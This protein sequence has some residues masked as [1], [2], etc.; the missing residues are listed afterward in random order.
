MKLEGLQKRF[1]DLHA[2]RD[3][4][5][6]IRQ[7]EFLT[8]LGPS[9][10]GKTTL[11]RIIAGFELADGGRV[12]LGGKDI[13]GL[14]ANVRPIN[15]V[16]QSYALFPHLTVFD[17]VAFGLVSRR[18]PKAE[19]AKKVATALEMLQLGAFASR[20]PHQLSGGQ[21][22]RVALA[23]ALVGEP[24]V[25]LLDEPMSAL[26]AKLRTEVQ[27]ELRRLQKRLGTTFVLVTHDQ[28]EA[29]TVSD[30]ICVLQGGRIQQIGTPEQV[31]AWPCN[32]FVAEFLGAANL[33]PARG[34]GREVD[35]PLGRLTLEENSG[36]TEGTLALRA[37]NVVLCPTRPAVNGVQA[38]VLERIYHGT[39]LEVLLSVA[40]KAEGRGQRANAPLEGVLESGVNTSVQALDVRPS[41]F[42]KGEAFTLKVRTAPFPP[43]EVGEEVWAQLPPH[44]LV[45][46][47]E[48]L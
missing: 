7:G 13:T 2:V 21:K 36:W 43:L 28:D 23:R 47:R 42:N 17:N 3:L 12:V 16:F 32:R 34:N 26:D 11:L 41:T 19:I 20:H 45:P 33:I 15:T 1:G 5:L 27:L 44:A 4:S 46:L 29:M 39:H 48:D 6:D 25:L 14:P 40:Q 10:C 18:T 38:T 37:E 24:E 8:L 22:Q 31:Y 9:G 30:R 35:T